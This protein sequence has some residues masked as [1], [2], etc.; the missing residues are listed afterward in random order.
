MIKEVKV[1]EEEEVVVKIEKEGLVMEMKE[2][3]G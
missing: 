2:I 1:E 3:M